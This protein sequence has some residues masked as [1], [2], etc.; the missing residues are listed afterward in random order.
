MLSVKLD[1]GIILKAID[2]G[3][4]VQL[5]TVRKSKNKTVKETWK[6]VEKTSPSESFVDAAKKQFEIIAQSE[7]SR[8]ASMGD[9][10]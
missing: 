1:N 10:V 2:L 9:R 6:N 5:R 3:N 7:N 8:I 4:E